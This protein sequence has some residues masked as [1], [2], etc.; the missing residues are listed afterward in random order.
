MKIKSIV[1][2]LCT[3]ISF[4]NTPL[5]A[6][7]GPSKKTDM[8]DLGLSEDDMK[9][10]T[11]F[12]DSLDEE[13]INALTAIGEEIIKEADEL[14]IDPFE[15]IEMQAKMQEEYDKTP[16]PAP[17]LA[18]GKVT[19]PEKKA[20]IV[21]VGMIETLENLIRLIG[22]IRQKA[23]HDKEYANQLIPYKYRLDDLVFYLNI[24]KNPLL[25]KYFSDKEFESLTTNIKQ[26]YARLAELEP[27]LNIKE[28]SLE[29]KNFYE[30]L[31]LPRTATQDEIVQT[32]Q[33]KIASSNPQTLEARLI[34]QGKTKEEI[35]KALDE[36]NA[37]FNS[38]NEAYTE[39]R[40]Q[41]E[42]K[43]IFDQILAA[44][45]Q[46]TDQQLIL[47][48]IKKLLKKHEPE[49]LKT[50]QER[51]K[52][53]A[54]ARKLQ[55]EALKKRALPGRMVFSMPPPLPP[56]SSYEPPV[57]GGDFFGSSSFGATPSLTPPTSAGIKAKGGSKGTDKAGKKKDGDK[58]K[59]KKKKKKGEDTKGGDKGK[60]GEKLPS[61]VNA[62]VAII[63][64]IIKD[65][66]KAIENKKDLLGSFK[67]LMTTP[68]TQPYLEDEIKKLAELQNFIK[69]DLKGILVTIPKK[70]KQG[71]GEL[72][73]DKTNEDIY[74]KAV[75]K[76]FENFEKQKPKEV[77]KQTAYQLIEP[78]LK[79]DATK[80]LQPKGGVL[81]P[82]D[83]AKLF[84]FTGTIPA[85][86]DVTKV[87]DPEIKKL[88]D[89][90]PEEDVDVEK[91]DPA[92]PGQTMTV[93]EKRRKNYF[94]ELKD[95]YEEAKEKV[96]EKKK[97]P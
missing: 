38:L 97:K 55:E 19:E 1:F 71:I 47:E 33:Q 72:K 95:A 31:D 26:L 42:A 73:K 78:L 4:N 54:E 5:Y 40:N 65:F 83:P 75:A 74:K 20:P 13:T 58:K 32:Y 37:S 87:T 88:N 44:F 76:E 81:T 2:F 30:I 82:L 70:I 6:S 93:K 23:A 52:V 53:E 14:G 60:A 66:S 61:K 68:L 85:G 80:Q 48:E 17:A 39:L 22:D 25:I 67:E 96:E 7:A 59:K 62:Q 91:P 41:E 16:P 77:G 9:M 15:Y 43:Y 18:P 21:D 90:N 45:S 84:V 79:F 3:L 36:V 24:L 50:Q 8:E 63:K 28:F 94:V 92:K 12:I 35:N 27:Q 89:L 69:I 34:R 57:S 64:S 46:A 49:A 51:E 10:F 11:E 29:G 56:F 86:I